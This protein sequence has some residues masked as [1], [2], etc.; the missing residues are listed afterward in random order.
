MTGSQSTVYR[1]TGLYKTG[2]IVSHLVSAVDAYR[3]IQNV[4]GIDDR[5]CK[6]TSALKVSLSDFSQ[7]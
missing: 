3:A 4:T 6:I 1:V 7:V 2:R 5:I